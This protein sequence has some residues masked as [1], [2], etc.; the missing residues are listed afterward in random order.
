LAVGLLVSGEVRADVCVYPWVQVRQV[1]GVVVDPDGRP[2]S[3]A[4]VA[5]LKDD[6]Q[7]AAQQ[8]KADG[9]FSFDG[10]IAGRYELRVEARGFSRGYYNLILYK[11]ERTWRRMIRVPL[12]VVRSG[13]CAPKIILEKRAHQR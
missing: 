8:S 4:K 12:D 9:G 1:L 13:G 10:L 5:V 7:I 11:P 6:V 2:I 3:E